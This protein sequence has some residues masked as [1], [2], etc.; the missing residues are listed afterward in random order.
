ML[1]VGVSLAGLGLISACGGSNGTTTKTPPPP[2][3]KF[4]VYGQTGNLLVPLYFQLTV[5]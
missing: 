2:T 3:Y 1:L 5:N 4:L